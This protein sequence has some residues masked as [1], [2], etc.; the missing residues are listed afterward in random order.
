VDF[1]L[2]KA[3]EYCPIPHSQT[4]RGNKAGFAYLKQAAIAV[5]KTGI[6]SFFAGLGT[7]T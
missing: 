2:G 3:V 4:G 5:H 1:Q 6:G 7:K